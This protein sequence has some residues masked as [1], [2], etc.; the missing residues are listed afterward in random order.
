MKNTFILTCLLFL[1][2]CKKE[3]IVQ[4]PHFGEA[5]ALLNGVDWRGKANATIYT[6]DDDDNTYSIQLR[7]SIDNG[8]V[9][10]SGV[11]GVEDHYILHPDSFGIAIR[12]VYAAATDRDLLLGRYSLDTLNTQFIDIDLVSIEEQLIKGRFQANFVLSSGDPIA[13]LGDT[14]SFKSGRFTA[15]IWRE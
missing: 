2:A 9:I 5:S 12:K 15:P 14:L 1:L 6:G 8:I 13:N 3:E 4:P 10:F 11:P 7:T